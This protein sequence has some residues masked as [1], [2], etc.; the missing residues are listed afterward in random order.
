MFADS[1]AGSQTF[2]CFVV[3]GHR[4]NYVCEYLL[5]LLLQF[6]STTLLPI[7]G[8]SFVERFEHFLIL[9]WTVYSCVKEFFY[10]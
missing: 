8:G 9:L 3:G 4:L 1:A 2:L 7:N 5:L 6:A 10:A